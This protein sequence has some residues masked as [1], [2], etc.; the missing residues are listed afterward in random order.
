MKI[1]IYRG[2]KEIGGTCIE[3][4]ADNGKI[5][6]IDL[7]A[8]L[9]D[10]NPNIDYANNKVDA[11]LISHPHQ[12]HFGLMDKIGPNVPIYIGELS[13]DLINTTRIFREMPLLSGNYI[14][15]KPWKNFTIANTFWVT[16]YL[17]DHST[18]EAFAFLI[19]ADGKRIFYSGDFRS[20]GRK[21]I[22]FTNLI[23]N[24]PK[25][26]DILL[27]EGTMVER[28]NH[29]YP[30]EES[31]ETAIFKTIKS[32][33][34]L[35]FVVSSA[36]NIDRFISVFKACKGTGKYLVI[37]VYTA[38][39]LDILSKQS[40]NTP[41][42]EWKEIKVF[43]HPKQLEKI[44]DEQFDNFRQRINNQKIKNEVFQNPSNFVYF[45]RCPNE[46]LV[47][48]LKSKGRIN[49]IYSQWEGYIKEEHQTY[50]TKY[51]NKLKID[52][53]CSFHSIHTSGHATVTDLIQFAKALNSN[54]IIPIHTAFPEKFKVEFEKEG[55]NNVNLW[56]DNKE[57]SL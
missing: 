17:T 37:D 34:N 4:I 20:T 18:P 53:D 51:I 49:I 6:W 36:Q 12:D 16:P 43:E 35:S 8:P 14:K 44:K 29:L 27:M 54:K 46:K 30:T 38:L 23:E 24:P 10:S 13:L 7:G 57:Y 28:S 42:I 15:I 3:L 31:V 40:K 50:C 2:T 32:Q 9:D 25:K 1:K 22:V 56:E 47:N 41:K 55:L 39:I 52:S 21:N 45:V 48:A 19:E 33:T 26:I 5:L 11:L